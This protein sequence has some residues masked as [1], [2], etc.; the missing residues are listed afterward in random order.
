MT[1][2]D[3]WQ[4]YTSKNPSFLDSGATFTAAGLKKFFDQTWEQAHKQGV[5]NGRALEKLVKADPSKASDPR[6]IFEQV[7]GKNPTI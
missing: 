3:L 7:F 6:S 4:I 1:Q 2:Q 5:E